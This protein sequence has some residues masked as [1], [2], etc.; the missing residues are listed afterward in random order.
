VNPGT[1]STALTELGLGLDL[2]GAALIGG[3][4]LCYLVHWRR[5]GT[6]LLLWGVCALLFGLAVG[7]V[8]A[9]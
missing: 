9:A 5:I 8:L 7:S 4:A 3:A 1:G 2:L 6:V